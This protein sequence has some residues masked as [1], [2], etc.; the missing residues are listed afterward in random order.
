[1]HRA[2]YSVLEL[3]VCLALALV[4][5]GSAAPV[6]IASRDGVRAIG[7]TDFLVAQ[8]HAARMEA[9]KRQSHVALRFETDGDDYL[10]AVYVDGNGNGIRASDIIAG[11]DSLLRPRERLDQQFAGVG[12]GF[13]DGVPD[14]DGTDALDNR[15][16]IRV[17]RSRMLSFSPT[18]TSSTGTV[19]LHGRGRRQ[20]AVRVLGGTGRIRSLT[21]DFGAQRWQPR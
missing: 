7:A 8:L 18:G 19:Y 2:A 5:C 16:P 13:E 4:V 14:V 15:D 11:I 17:G 9:L 10:L 3:L 20:L 1:M 6:L 12:F 21:F